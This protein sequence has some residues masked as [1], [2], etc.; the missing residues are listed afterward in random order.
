MG[1]EIALSPKR[2][3]SVNVEAVDDLDVIE[4]VKNG[5]IIQREYPG[6]ELGTDD[7]PD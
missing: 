5:R 7:W 6:E 4:V 2:H 3:I 1:S